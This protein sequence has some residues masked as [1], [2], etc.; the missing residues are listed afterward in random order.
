MFY[1]IYR[2]EEENEENGAE[3]ENCYFKP[4]E[5][6]FSLLC[7]CGRCGQGQGLEAVSGWGT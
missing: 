6:P 2:A 1:H 7:V 5:Y 3:E 4:T